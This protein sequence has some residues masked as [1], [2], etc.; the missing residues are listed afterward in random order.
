MSMERG[1][2]RASGGMLKPAAEDVGADEN[3][4]EGKVETQRM[5][6][7]I[8]GGR[9]AKARA[10]GSARDLSY[11][12]TRGYNSGKLSDKLSDKKPSQGSTHP[13]GGTRKEASGQEGGRKENPAQKKGR[14]SS[15]N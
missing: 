2:Q 14:R 15:I 7:R 10:S 8:A 6:W 4:Q 11:R 13:K 9:G 12:S 3:D 1:D 5:E